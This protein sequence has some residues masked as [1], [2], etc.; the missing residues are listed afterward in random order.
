MMVKLYEA[1]VMHA[2]IWPKK[3]SFTHRVFCCAIDLADWDKIGEKT[4]LMGTGGRAL[5]QFR[6]QDFLPKDIV[7]QPEGKSQAFGSD[8]DRL[9][10]R[11]KSF[12]ASQGE[13]IPAHAQITL[14][15]MPRAFGKSYNPVIFFMI[16][17]DGELQC[18]IAEVNN[19]FGER[20]AWFLGRDCKQKN[21]K[22][23]VFLKLRTPKKFYVSPFSG[24]DTEFEFTL[25]SPGE[26]L[27]VGVD[28]YEGGQKTLISTWTG[29]SV[30]LTD[31]RLCW[32]TIKIPFLIFKVIALIHLHALNLW[33]IKRLSFKR[34]ADDTD[35][36][37]NLRHPSPEI[38]KQK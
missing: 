27:C 30:P 36:Q 31:S 4:W 1:K 3:N 9:A 12:C 25:K 33:L 22:G 23:E 37:R 5:Y 8:N 18:G 21:A 2:R 14:V 7:F 16:S 29:R 13:V 20:K 17:W 35:L 34:K 11:V 28:H 15:A 32:L 38:S 10:N 19:T 26:S 24:L 6:D